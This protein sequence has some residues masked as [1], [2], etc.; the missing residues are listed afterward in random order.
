MSYSILGRTPHKGKET[1][2]TL[3]HNGTKFSF[4][5]NPD[6]EGNWYNLEWFTPTFKG[7]PGSRLPPN[8][9]QS[10][11]FQRELTILAKE[12]GLDEP[13]GFVKIKPE[14]VKTTEAREPRE[15]LTRAKPGLMHGFN[16]FK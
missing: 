13:Y 16:P 4:S 10:I 8:T 5:R 3:R 9:I 15:K 12:K 1:M 11:F 6:G 7:D 2:P 14:P